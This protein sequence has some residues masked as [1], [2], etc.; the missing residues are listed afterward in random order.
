MARSEENV[1]PT[2][3][4]VEV[5]VKTMFKTRWEIMYFIAFLLINCYFRTGSEGSKYEVIKP[6]IR[7]TTSD[8]AKSTIIVNLRPKLTKLFWMSSQKMRLTARTTQ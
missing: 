4:T 1:A 6:T 8:I 2:M 3:L 7:S 5:P